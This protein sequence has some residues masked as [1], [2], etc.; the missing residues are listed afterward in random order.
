MTHYFLSEST[1]MD[2]Y[3]A[4]RRRHQKQFYGNINRCSA[5]VKSVCSPNK[6]EVSLKNRCP[7]YISTTRRFIT[8]DGVQNKSRLITKWLEHL[9]KENSSTNI[10]KVTITNLKNFISHGLCVEQIKQENKKCLSL[11]TSKCLKDKIR[12][13]QVNRMKMEDL[14]PLLR[15]NPDMYVIHYVRDPRAIAV[16]RIAIRKLT[17]H[18][19]E[20]QPIG[21]ARFLCQRIRADLRHRRRLSMKYPG[22]ITQIRYEDLAIN[23]KDTAKKIYSIFGRVP[24]KRWADFVAKH[25]HAPKDG[26]G[27]GISVRNAT[28]TTRKWRKKIPPDQLQSIN[29]ICADVI[30]ALGYSM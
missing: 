8:E 14:E 23:P 9:K 24:T 5:H 10:S 11:A 22:A 27:F 21:E 29:R 4:C 7:D 6:V 18:P 15:N 28:E 26:G 3:V 13:V 17:W 20:R 1:A 12:V 30:H 16:S 2:K 25:M 19:N